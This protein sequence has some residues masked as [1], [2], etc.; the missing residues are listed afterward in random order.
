MIARA[1]GACFT[2]ALEVAL[3]CDFVYTTDS[4]KFGDT[5]TK[6]G[7]RPTWGMSQTLSRAVGQRR[8]RELSFHRSNIYRCSSGRVGR[9][10]RKL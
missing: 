10:K 5:H 3:H 6:F 4:T 7:L 2:G 1:V 9:G 8:A